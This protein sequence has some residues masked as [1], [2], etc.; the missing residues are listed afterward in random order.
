[1]KRFA[2][3]PFALSLALAQSSPSFELLEPGDFH[4][5]E[6]TRSPGHWLGLVEQDGRY[7]LKDVEI[8]IDPV[9]D[10]LLD[11]DDQMTGKSVKANTPAR[12]LFFVRGARFHAGEVPTALDPKDEPTPLTTT[13]FRFL[14]KET[15]I[16][17]TGLDENKMPRKGSHLVVQS[18]N[19]R[20][21]IYEIR[22]DPNDAYWQILWAGD[23]DHD[24]KL[25]LYVQA[26]F[27]YNVA[28]HRLFLSSEAQ[29][30]EVVHQVAVF[31]TTGC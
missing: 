30:G 19:I 28:E 25:D 13:T 2:L 29:P 27:H 7:S 18:G 4:G 20:Q 24:G 31:Q 3:L 15:V 23:L 8:T 6:I 22:Q 14:G 12:A 21:V 17:A 1:M 26:S 9:K 10:D 5:E 11:S 16:E